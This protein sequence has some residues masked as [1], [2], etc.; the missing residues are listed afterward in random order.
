MKQLIIAEKPSVARDLA[1]VLKVNKSGDF[2]ENNQWVI[3]SAVGHLVELP[4][5]DQI[6]PEL[7]SWKIS[8]L[9][10]LPKSFKLKP[11]EKTKKK[12]QELKKLL[13]R[14]DISTVINGCDAGREGEL[15]FTYIYE[16]AKCKL[17]IKRLWMQS[18][19]SSGIKKA[20]EDLRAN[21]EM[22]PLQ[23]AARSRSEADWLIGI[24][25]TRIISKKL[26]FRGGQASTVGRVQ[27]PTLGLIVKREEE[28][29]TFKSQ[30]YWRLEGNFSIE[31]GSYTGIYQRNDFKK[32]HQHDRIDRIWEK[33]I[34]EKL[35]AIISNVSKALVVEEKK[36]SKIGA[37][38][39]FDLTSLQR[40]ANG[41]FGLPA[42]KT[43]SIAQS[44]YEKHKVITYP[45]TD[46]KALPE[47]YPPTCRKIIES[48][49]SN[50]KPF[51]EPVLANNWIH[52]RNKKIFNN[53]QVSDHFAI[54]PTE[55]IPA[56][57][58]PEEEKIYQLITRRFLAIFHPAAE[59]D[60]TTRITSIDIHNFKTEGKVLVSPGWMAVTGRAAG[61]KGELPPITKDDGEPPLATIKDVILQSESTKPPPRY[62]EATL[63]G[64][65]E[66]AGKLVEDENY[67]EAMKERGLGTPATRAQ[68]IEH[69]I[70]EKYLIRD[71]REL[72][73]TAKADELIQ[74][75][76]TVKV[77]ELA[78]PDLTGDWEFKLHQIE[79]G[80]LT[81]KDFMKGIHRMTTDIVDKSKTFN[82][83]K[84]RFGTTKV[85]SPSDDKHF[86]ETLRFYRSEDGVYNIGKILGGRK[87][88]ESELENLLRN[89]QI[90]PFDDFRSK[91]GK[92]FSAILKL[93]DEN[94]VEFVF[95]K[96]SDDQDEALDLSKFPKVEGVCWPDGSAIVETPTAYV[97]ENYYLDTEKSPYRIGRILLGRPL[98]IEQIKKLCKTGKTDL[99]DKFRSN[100]TKRLFSAFLT[101][102]EKGKIGFEFAPRKTK[103]K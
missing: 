58:T 1:K 56:K 43:L 15:I 79:K 102:D 35:H 62:T 51:A 86:Y 36:R 103:N 33:D 48:L 49:K 40:D 12:F 70:Y 47:D 60:I 6:D 99:L 37:P 34:A 101:L 2:F 41:R 24:N 94:R 11:I 71:F 25:G 27:T 61:D 8:T 100:K 59:F 32:G 39:L 82:E 87:L 9:P 29:L 38:R 85:V 17:P 81:R 44:L 77:E 3:S 95:E 84:V 68:I 92:N 73:P 19:T 21:D 88:P 63:L 91:A 76:G 16:L 26:G 18:M 83:E 96:N 30:D 7:K 93:N 31:S 65:M 90:G 97:S 45:R 98:P 20:F 52:P 4:K 64:S 75:L 66:T 72:I 5:P 14:N 50:F 10:I 46:S 74:F 28:I 23:E 54:I 69:L 53:K 13:K 22:I 89:R 80:E 78:S 42:K 67:A 55:V 57:L